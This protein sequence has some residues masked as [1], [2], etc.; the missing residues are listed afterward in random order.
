MSGSSC[1]GQKQWASICLTACVGQIM[2]GI[3]VF[4]AA[5]MFLFGTSQAYGLVVGAVLVLVGGLGLL[6]VS[7]RSSNLLTV[8]SAFLGCR[9]HAHTRSAMTVL[10]RPWMWAGG[11]VV[12]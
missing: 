4:I 9:L 12:V 1:A 3:V 5:L 2:C 11:G 6:G 7:K 10:R 8:V